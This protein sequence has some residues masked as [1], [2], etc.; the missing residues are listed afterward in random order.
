MK[1]SALILA[2]GRGKRLGNREKA[3]IPF[4]GRP[5]IEHTIEVLEDIVDEIVISVRD[6]EQK[7]ALT[8]HVDKRPMVVDRYEDAGPLAGILEG[9]KAAKGEYVFVTACDMPFLNT[10]VVKMLFEFAQG[11]DAALPIWEN[12][13][14][15]P[16]HAVYRREP[17]VLQT[18][19]AIERG[20][21][22]V[23]APVFKLDDVVSVEMDE[24]KKID[25]R[26]RTFLNINTP[27]DMKM[28]DFE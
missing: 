6:T 21:R 19:K 11:H 2:G 12:G 24:I 1:R 15:E 23:L 18:E 22:F 8:E 5:I 3:L 13:R 26:L 25:P 4:K 20:D 10:D 7:E 17:M 14:Y 28:L 16:L 9:F 27:E